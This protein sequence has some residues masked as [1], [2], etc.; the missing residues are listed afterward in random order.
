MKIK[1]NLI[2]SIALSAMLIFGSGQA[3]HANTEVE[4]SVATTTNTCQDSNAKC[5]G[6][7]KM[8]GKN[9]FK[10]SVNELQKSGILTS[11]DVKNIDA[12]HEKLREQRKEEMKKK[13]EA[14]IDNMVN[15][16]VITAEKGEKL[17]ETINKKIEAEIKELEEKN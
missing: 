8:M 4:D 10:E 12:Y 14:V 13:R 6:H 2:P 17:K 16:K 5:P 15:E 1:K 9:V 7:G 3:I 11:E